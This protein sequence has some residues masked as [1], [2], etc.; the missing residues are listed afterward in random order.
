MLRQPGSPYVRGRSKAL[1]K[2]KSFFDA[3][4][5][6]LNY[7]PGAGRHRGRVGAL[8]VVS[9]CGIRFK[10]G[11]GLTDRE[12]EHPLPN[13]THRIERDHLLLRYRAFE[14]EHLCE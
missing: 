1:L 10:V 8:Q 12:R 4:A 7:S 2:V 5:R 14:H 9:P 11:T 6:V 3:E 13:H